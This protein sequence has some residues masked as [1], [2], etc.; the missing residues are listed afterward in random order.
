MGHILKAIGVENGT[1]SINFPLSPR[2]FYP[3]YPENP[4]TL[5]E[6][7]R[8]ARIDRGLLIKELGELIG[9]NEA[10]VINWEIRGRRPEDKFRQPLKRVL[11]IDVELECSE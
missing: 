6:H 3:E 2:I 11:D 8:K 10:S 5:G 4:K 7:I 9:A 1:Y